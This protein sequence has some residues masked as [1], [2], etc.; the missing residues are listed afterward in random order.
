MR[1]TRA[2]IEDALLDLLGTPGGVQAI[3]FKSVAKRAGV[4]EMTVYRHYPNRK[5]LLRGLWERLNRNLG[6]NVGMPETPEGLLRQH[7]E[8]FEGFARNPALIL[9]SLTTP[10]GRAMRA[11]LN[12]ARRKAFLG[13]VSALAPGLDPASRTRA[14]AVVQ[15]LHSAH[16]WASMQEQWDLSG[17][18]AGAATRWALDILFNALR[19]NP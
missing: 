8:L 9:A 18:E 3:T 15:L 12:P 1:L 7:A 16:A 19:R 17:T 14:A 11:A 5:A 10:E 6:P 4:T 2:R 13:V